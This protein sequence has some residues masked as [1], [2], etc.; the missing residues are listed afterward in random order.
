MDVRLL[1]V[2]PL[3]AIPYVLARAEYALVDLFLLV[4]L[5][6]LWNLPAGYAG[7]TSFGQQAY[8][9]TGA[10]ALYLFAA[11]GIDPAFGVVLA[12]LTAAIVALPVSLVVLRL[13]AGY[14]AVATWVVAEVLRLFV[15]LSPRVGGNT[16]VSLPGTGRYP[17]VL[18]QAITYW[19]SLG[20]MTACVGGVYL[21]MRSRFGLRARAV[22]ADP[23]AAAATGVAVGR[24]RRIAY[25]LSALGTGAVG[26]VLFCHHLYA[27]PA[28]VFGPQYSVAMLFMVLIGGL[29]TIEG[30]ILGAL[31]Y[32]GLQ[33]LL[34][35]Y[36]P[37]YLVVLGTVAMLVTLF[38]PR[39]L[40]GGPAARRA[41]LF[42][43]SSRY[44]PSRVRRNARPR[45]SSP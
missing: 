27:A 21:L 10:Y 31:L 30:P 7:L 20:L 13:N 38:A 14:F 15:T 28:S 44:G 5:A 22:A 26:A 9:G 39:G 36:G 35:G 18:W 12:A 25:L 2:L 1:A 23:V 33:Q 24:V 42:P 19:W 11:A 4:C 45:G 8:L 40:C 17:L 43:I 34:A 41:S 6:S 29:G 32:F 37:W 16:G 3:I